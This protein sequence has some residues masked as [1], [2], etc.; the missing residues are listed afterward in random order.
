MITGCQSFNIDDIRDLLLHI[1]ADA[2]PQN[3]LRMDN[4][5]LVQ[6]VA[7]VLGLL[8]PTAATAP[9]DQTRMH[10]VHSTFFN[11]PV[12][13]EAAT[14]R[15][16][17]TLSSNNFK[18]NGQRVPSQYMLTLEQMIE[19]D[20][21]NLSYMADAFQK[22]TGWVETPH[23]TRRNHTRCSGITAKA[24][25]KVTTTHAEVQAH[26][27]GLLSP[28]SSGADA[29]SKRG[30]GG[31][32]P[33]ED[34]R[35]CLELPKKKVETGQADYQA[36]YESTLERMARSTPRRA[37]GGVRSIRSAV[38]DQGDPTTMHEDDEVAKQ[39]LE[40]LPSHDF[41]FTRL[42]SLAN[43]QK[44]TSRTPFLDFT[45]HSD[46]RRM[47]ALNARK[48]QFETAI[49]SG[50]APEGLNTR[51][52]AANGKDLGE[53]CNHVPKHIIVCRMDNLVRIYA[54]WSILVPDQLNAL[55][56]Q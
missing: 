53:R 49:R 8:L 51:W 46:S 33:E 28:P 13:G 10:G 56:S 15:L 30:E 44:C 18:H 39:P 2:P 24:L 14:Q 35:A 43:L 22:P 48:A 4:A 1:V 52:T 50:K 41:T 34:A 40:T 17:S 27:P 21:P 19:N 36:D 25:E 54:R 6:K 23:S 5:H 9:R 32:D 12:S 31:H 26:V 55:V 38:V 47:S 11:G 29:K 37:G 16:Q 42:M 20:Y 45:G 3:W 7:A